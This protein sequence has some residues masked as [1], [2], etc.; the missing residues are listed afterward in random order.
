MTEGGFMPRSILRFLTLGILCAAGAFGQQGSFAQIAYGGSWQ[1]TFTLLNLSTTD[2]GSVTLSFFG[3]DGLPLN[4]P[5]QGAGNTTSYTFTIPAGGTQ[6]VVLS[7]PGSGITQGWATMSVASGVVRGQGSFRFLTQAGQIS[8]AVVPLSTPGTAL[9][10]FPFPPSPNPVILIPFDNTTGQY[11][12][13]LAIANTTNAT[14]PVPIE[15]V[16]SSNAPLASDTINLTAMQH[17]AF[18]TRLNYPAV[19]GKKGTLRIH[20]SASSVTVL[21]LLSNATNAITTIIPVTQ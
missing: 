13:S 15:F 10:I 3:D 12:T 8:E 7:N 1:T 11:V 20:A 2:L 14:L 19:D 9:C 18:V 4:A 6:N 21:G 5:V 17:T 16:D